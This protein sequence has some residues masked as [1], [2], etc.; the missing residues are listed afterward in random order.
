MVEKMC[1]DKFIA[2][3][4]WPEPRPTEKGN[5]E[6]MNAVSV[7][8]RILHQVGEALDALT[9]RLAPVLQPAN[10]PDDK[11]AGATECFSVP[12][13]ETIRVDLLEPARESREKI[14]SIIERLGV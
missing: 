9:D 14:Q 1:T 13:A 2:G 11:A 12:L 6:V 8:G 10:P 5:P 7:A 4:N 3:K